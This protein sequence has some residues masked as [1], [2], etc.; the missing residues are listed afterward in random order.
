VVVKQIQVLV[1]LE[2]EQILSVQ[3][4]LQ[5]LVEQEILHL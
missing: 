1:D 4:E 5:T 3:L 2:E